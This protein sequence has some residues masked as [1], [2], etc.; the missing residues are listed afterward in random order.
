MRFR[1]A[2]K[3]T[4]YAVA[5]SSFFA[6]AFSGLLHPIL[7]LLSAIGIAGSWFWEPP[8]VRYER[9]DLAWTIVAVLVFIYQTLSVLA[10]SEIIIAGSNFLL[11]LLIVKLFNR[12][13]S[14][15]YLHVYVLSFLMLTAGTVLNAEI[16]YGFFFLC[17]VV[18]STWALTIFHLRRELENNF[19]LRHSSQDDSER[20]RVE[21]VMNSKRIVGRKFFV[22]TGLVSLFVFGGALSLFLLF[23]RIGFGLFFDK[24]RGGVTM[25]GFS[26]G[27]QLGGHGLIKKDNTVVMR[28]NV[29]KAYRGRNAPALHWRGVAF[30]NYNK[31]EWKRTRRAPMTERRM[32]RRER[33]TA[34]H[35]LYQDTHL[36]DR[37]LEARLDPA[38]KQE[39]YLEPVG[40]SVL[41]GASK[42]LAY[43]FENKLKTNT[44][45]GQ[46][47]ELRHPHSAGIKYTV[48]SDP[49]P[50]SATELRSAPALMPQ[51]YGVY[52]Q[53]PEELPECASPQ[54]PQSRED[55]DPACRVRDLARFITRDADNQFDKA[56]AIESWLRSNLDY[57][58]KMESPGEVEPV[59][60]FLFQR[61]KGHCE[62]FS[63]A[64]AILGR[65]VGLPIRN[66]NG[67]LGGEWNEYDDYIAVRAGDAHS[68][69]EVYFAGYG[70]V[71]FDP[72]PGGE[73]DLLG[74]GSAGFLDRMRRIADT[75]R[76]KW[77]KW[78][79]EYD[80]YQQLKL[81]KDL[82]KKLKGSA[83]KYF[84]SPLKGAKDWA[85]RH[86]KKA[87]ALVI[88]VGVGILLF[89][90]WRRRR[91][92]IGPQ[93]Q[94]KRSK[95]VR[96]P[97]VTHYLA[98]SRLLRKRGYR[99][100][101]ATTPREFASRLSEEEVPGADAYTRLTEMYYQ[102]EYSAGPS[103]KAQSA[104]EL[105][106]EIQEALR[107][108][109]PKRRDIRA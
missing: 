96:D 8:R 109:K 15:D 84:K 41:F 42:P 66:V 18:S 107:D 60:F 28:A 105:R 48:Y 59:E 90:L 6:V 11:F 29:G 5:L 68:W 7:V 1:T 75:M 20:I 98:A 92:G 45:A 17:Y 33:T 9:W 57:T 51:D 70:W 39:I 85:K 69:V 23:P 3:S 103:A 78:V 46:N 99:R 97:V 77:F 106:H 35:L 63:S 10:G 95:R 38:L 47:D 87:A 22:G 34:H 64:M 62:Y 102:A 80:L 2:H 24:G 67:F 104:Q 72:T 56:L 79:I 49:K 76:F 40:Y 82:G 21:R 44:R 55:I 31:G 4:T 74:R 89:A 50:P 27:V 25:A 30:D 108:H 13:E 81:F 61:Q 73:S 86:R 36:K 65:S 12:R 91:R 93:S 54:T 32:V 58:L 14:K 37:Q 43:V 53:I 83:N 88:L 101:D 52:L 16:T 26:D 19:L 100:S 94:G 71:T